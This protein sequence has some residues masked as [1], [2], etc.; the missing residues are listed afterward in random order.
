MWKKAILSLIGIASSQPHAAHVAFVHG[1]SNLWLLLC[2]TTPNACHLLEPLE[3]AIRVNL[4][5]TFTG[6]PS[7]INLECKL[8]GLPVRH[9]G[10]NIV[11]PPSLSREYEPY[12]S[13]T[14]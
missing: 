1:L 5:L 11:S 14:L 8:F 7:P 9:G 12:V 2:R 3:K 13:L 6:H 10:L 4:T